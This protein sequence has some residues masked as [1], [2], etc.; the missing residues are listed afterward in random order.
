MWWVLAKMQILVVNYV[1][2]LC[3]VWQ[4]LTISKIQVDHFVR[5]HGQL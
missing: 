5:C 2:L 1:I 4:I 3:I